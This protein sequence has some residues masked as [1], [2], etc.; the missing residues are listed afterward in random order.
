MRNLRANGGCDVLVSYLVGED[1]VAAPHVSL[2][3]VHGDAGGHS[4]SR[5]ERGGPH[6]EHRARFKPATLRHTLLFSSLLPSS[7]SSSSSGPPVD[8][9]SVMTISSNVL[10]SFYVAPFEV[11]E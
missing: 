2:Q 11:D 10:S 1:V 7:S 4:E 8:H 5:E 3:L 6:S 9:P